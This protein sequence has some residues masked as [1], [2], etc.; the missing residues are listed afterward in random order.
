MSDFKPITSYFDEEKATAVAALFVECASP[1]GRDINY[2]KLLKLMYILERKAIVRWGHQV[3]GGHYF[4]FDYGPVL[5]EV[6]SLILGKLEHDK[7][8]WSN[9]I[10]T[11]APDNYSIELKEHP[12][13]QCLSGAEIK[14]INEVISQYGHYT[15]WELS[16]LSHDAF[17]EWKD[18]NGS[19]LPIFWEDILK[20]TE[21]TPE[22]IYAVRK[23]AEEMELLQSIFVGG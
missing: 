9:F 10:T 3:I 17:P 2:M 4:S 8:I 6:Y 7:G 13:H 1:S 14:L 16:K 18:P 12:D 23:D 5:S 11:P 20:A 21:K 22:E 19:R 15:E